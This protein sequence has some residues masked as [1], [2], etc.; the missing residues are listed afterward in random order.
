M[1]TAVRKFRYPDLCEHLA[2]EVTKMT[3]VQLGD[4]QRSMVQTRLNKRVQDLGY[5][6]IDDYQAYYESNE[7][8][9]IQHIVSLLTTHYTY[10]FREF[11]HFEFISEQA[12]PALVPEL[13]KRADK[14]LNVWSA[15]ASRGQEVYSLAMYLKYHL[16]THGSDLKFRILGTDVDEQSIRIAR[17]GVYPRREIREVPLAYLGNHWA[18]GTGD[19]AEFVKAKGTLRDCVRFEQANLLDFKDRFEGQKFDIIFCRNV[20]IY[21]TPDQIRTSTAMLLRHLEPQGYFFIGISETLNGL[22]FDL[23]SEGP[24][25]YRLRQKEE[26]MSAVIPIREGV[27]VP[28]GG[29]RPIRVFCVDDSPSVHS[30]MKQILKTEHGFEIVGTAVNGVDAAEK[31]KNLP[32]VDVVTLDIHMPEQNGVEYLEKHFSSQHPPVVM[33]SSVSRDQSEVAMRTLELGASDFIEKPALNKLQERGE[34]IRAK[35]K[36]AILMRR[37]G[38]NQPVDLDSQFKKRLEIKNPG[39]KAR[40]LVT[41]MGHLKKTSSFLQELDGVQP[42]VYLL[43]E[44]VEGNLSA[45]ADQVSK[46]SG[47]KVVAPDAIF[48]KAKPGEVW[49]LDYHKALAVLPGLHGADRI[50]IG[51]FGELGKSASQALKSWHFGQL[52]LEDLGE[53]KGTESLQLYATDVFPFTSFAFMGTE[54][55][56]KN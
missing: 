38:L 29:V 50:G 5:R 17:N 22:G 9:E 26:A 7:K 4:K 45:I 15:A 40:V 47:R 52:L 10:F 6:T 56:G 46:I 37:T 39:T 33:V 28:Q 43:F 41:G 42:P 27:A 8:S 13:R 18:R 53:G 1:S 31:L 49:V 48:S 54:F 51:V 34:E 25:I 2:L 24:S 19:I 55:F 23:K 14:T 12:L 20:F 30:L 36:S 44:G 16:Q 11:S 35:L 32:N 21:F 3:G